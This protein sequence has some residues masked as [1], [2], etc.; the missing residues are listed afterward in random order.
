MERRWDNDVQDVEDVPG[1]VAG[2]A[3]RK[4]GDVEGFDD[5]MRNDF[6]SGRDQQRYDDN[7]RW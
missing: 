5:G 6:D 3:G 4:V 2:W 7:D 1:D